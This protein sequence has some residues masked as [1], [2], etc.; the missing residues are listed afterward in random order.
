MIAHKG[1]ESLDNKLGMFSGYA[2]LGLPIVAAYEKMKVSL[3][4][5][6]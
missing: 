6:M 2:V 1:Q 3:A 5:K 4:C